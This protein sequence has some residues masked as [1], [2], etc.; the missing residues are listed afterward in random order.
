MN[1]WSRLPRERHELLL[2]K[3][4]ERFEP[5]WRL[6]FALER[7]AKANYRASLKYK[8]KPYSGEVC[9][10][11]AQDRSLT[12]K[13]DPRLLWKRLIPKG[14]SILMLP[15]G[16]SGQMLVNPNVKELGAVI[17]SFLKKIDRGT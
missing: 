15:G 4:K 13:N 14:L 8:A 17:S 3:L 6:A 10:I 5:E 7:V 16:D 1:I 11:L 12:S 2:N 9:L